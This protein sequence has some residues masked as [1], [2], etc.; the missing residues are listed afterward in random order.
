L[1]N[2]S[3]RIAECSIS[4]V[5]RP[6]VSNLKDLAQS[7]SWNKTTE[8]IQE[9]MKVEINDA[10]PL[11]SLSQILKAGNISEKADKSQIRAMSV[12]F[13]IRSPVNPGE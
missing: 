8:T 11:R 3:C 7:N 1:T 13:L 12:S 5:I 4:P 2:S 9:T 6:H 10:I